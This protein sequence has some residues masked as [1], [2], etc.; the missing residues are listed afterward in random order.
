MA[1]HLAQ[2]HVLAHEKVAKS[3]YYSIEIDRS[4][5]DAFDTWFVQKAKA[6]DPSDRAHLY[7]D[8]GDGVDHYSGYDAR[9]SFP[10]SFVS[11][12]NPY[13][14]AIGFKRPP[15]MEADWVKAAQWLKG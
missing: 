1:W 10:P 11:N 3:E 9:Y 5:W 4:K 13:W 6:W 15:I 12:R 2:E 7:D 14:M 8:I